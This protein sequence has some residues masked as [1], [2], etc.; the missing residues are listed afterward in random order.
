M[1]TCLKYSNI[2]NRKENQDFV[3]VRELGENKVLY[4]VA[5]GMGGYSH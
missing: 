3:L 2:G 4:I 1:M 5:D